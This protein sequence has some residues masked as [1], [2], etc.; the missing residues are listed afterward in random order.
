MSPNEVSN[1]I[2]NS[3]NAESLNNRD[4]DPASEDPEFAA[5]LARVQAAPCYRDLPL[6]QQK[7]WARAELE[8][9]RFR[10]LLDLE[11]SRTASEVNADRR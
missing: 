6:R 8:A 4:P 2:N 7:D 11:N 1:E 5:M 10:R 9:A 3:E